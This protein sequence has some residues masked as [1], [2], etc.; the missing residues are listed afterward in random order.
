[1]A[2]AKPL[3]A[4]LPL[5]DAA[6]ER[7]PGWTA[8]AKAV[9]AKTESDPGADA[10]NDDQ[11]WLDAVNYVRASSPR[12][13]TSLAFG[14]L[15]SLGPPELVLAFS[16]RGAFHRTIIAGSGRTHVEQML[17]AHLGRPV[18]LRVEEASGD[19]AASLSPAEREAKAKGE[20]D[21]DVQDK[22]RSHPSVQT[23]LRVL[24]GEIEQI[25]LLDSERPLPSPDTSDETS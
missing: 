21:R 10:V 13:G 6:A 11:R 4:K 18:R 9:D 1:M 25:Q 19:A 14:H 7:S 24:R 12:L 3:G 17:S 20:R 22:V 23:A 8:A 16:R 5:T 15:V 2:Q